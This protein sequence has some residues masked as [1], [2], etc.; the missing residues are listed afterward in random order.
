GAERATRVLALD[1]RHVGQIWP[2]VERDADHV[3]PGLLEQSCRNRAVDAA[4][5]TDDDARHGRILAR[6]RAEPRD[7]YAAG[8]RTPRD[9]ATRCSGT[10]LLA[11]C[12][13]VIAVV[14]PATRSPSC[15]AVRASSWL[16]AA[17]A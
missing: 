3:V 8:L 13:A 15:S 17:I 9:Y 14:K 7:F 1:L 10:T 16:R 6:A 4:G 12:V 2:D 11:R 5:H